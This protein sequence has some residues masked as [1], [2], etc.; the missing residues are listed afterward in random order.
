LGFLVGDALEALVRRDGPL[1][2]EKAADYVLQACEGLAEAHAVGIV[3][4]D[5][6]PANLFLARRSDGS[7]RVK[8][9]DFGISKLVPTGGLPDVGMTSTQALMGSPLYMSPEQLR[10]SK[11]V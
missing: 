4:R 1:T 2:A 11:N 6:K 5:L 7:I 9:L 8:L 3:H 10:S